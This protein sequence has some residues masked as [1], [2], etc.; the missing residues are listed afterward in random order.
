ML[1]KAGLAAIALGGLFRVQVKI[2][3][4][5]EFRSCMLTVCTGESDPEVRAATDAAHDAVAL[6]TTHARL[7]A[8]A[9]SASTCGAFLER[10]ALSCSCERVPHTEL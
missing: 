5:N 1:C 7:A 4:D 10:Q 9:A 2:K 6:C 3:C 8:M